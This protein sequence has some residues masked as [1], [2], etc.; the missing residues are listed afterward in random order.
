MTF[1]AN[2]TLVFSAGGALKVANDAIPAGSGTF[3]RSQ[4]A[5]SQLP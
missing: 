3:V 4:G 5:V 2:V 1:P